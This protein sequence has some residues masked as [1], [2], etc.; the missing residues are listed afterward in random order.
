MSNEGSDISVN[1]RYLNIYCAL[2]VSQGTDGSVFGEGS[3]GLK[4]PLH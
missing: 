1:G 4:N 3:G 2:A